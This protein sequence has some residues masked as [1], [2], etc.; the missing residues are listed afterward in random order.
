[1][2]TP[3]A[4]TDTVQ[5]VGLAGAALHRAG[6]ALRRL[7]QVMDTPPVTAMPAEHPAPLPNSPG[8]PVIRL[9]GVCARWPAAAADALTDLDLDL[10]PGARIV[11]T[12]ESGSGKSTLLA[13]LLGFLTPTAGRI[14]VDGI[15]A[16]DLDPDEL[17]TLFSWCDQRAHVF[18]STVLENVRLA[19]PDADDAQVI[20]ALRDAG[21][22]AWLDELPLGADTGVGEHGRAISGGERARVALARGIL[23]GRPV[24]LADEPAAHLDQATADAVTARIM[25]PDPRHCVVLVTHRPQ[26]EALAD[27]VIR[28]ADG[29]RMS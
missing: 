10:V 19:R 14:T 6:S 20:A 3:L 16:A 22:G 18:D 7:F 8:G 17:R 27:Q 13:V 2:L 11:I 21:A 4:L 29:R 15:D 25:R 1:V 24:L 9:R 28:L 26:D 5:A 23:A 12:G